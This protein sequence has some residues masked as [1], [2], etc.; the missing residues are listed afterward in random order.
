MD[1]NSHKIIDQ[2]SPEILLLFGSTAST[3]GRNVTDIHG[4]GREK[5]SSQQSRDVEYERKSKGEQE[6]ERGGRRK[7]ERK[8]GKLVEQA[9]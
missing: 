3:L 5:V 8:G 1:T 6:I 7:L 9:L 2:V 4:D